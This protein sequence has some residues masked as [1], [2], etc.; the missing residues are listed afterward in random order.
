M[1]FLDYDIL[2]IK[3]LYHIAECLEIGISIG[4]IAASVDVHNLCNGNGAAIGALLAFFSG[5]KLVANG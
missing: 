3:A 5:L 2:R 1:L 4:R